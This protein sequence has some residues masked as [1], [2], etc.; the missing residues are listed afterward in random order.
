MRYEDLTPEERSRKLQAYLDRIYEGDVEQ[1]KES[2]QQSL[3]Q[4]EGVE[5][6]D[7]AGPN[8]AVETLDMVLGNQ[9]SDVQSLT[10]LET[11]E[12]V[13]HAERGKRPALDI[14]NGSYS[15]PVGDW[16]LLGD[17]STKT[18]IEN[19][20]PSIGRVELPE[21]WR[22]PYG[23]T[24]FVVGHNLLMTNRHVAHLFANGSGTRVF[25]FQRS[26]IDFRREL[27]RRGQPA[28][29]AFEITKVKMIHPYWDMAI[30]DVNP[31]SSDGYALPGPIVLS[32][33]DPS[34][35]FGDNVVVIGYPGDDSRGNVR[36]HDRIFRKYGHKRLQP[37]KLRDFADYESNAQRIVK[38]PVKNA[39]DHD[40]STLGGNSGSAVLL[41]DGVDGST[42]ARVVG[43]HFAGD[44]LER[45]YAVPVHELAKDSRV[46]DAGVQFTDAPPTSGDF[47]P[48]LWEKADRHAEELFPHAGPMNALQPA[49]QI[50][51]E[52]LSDHNN[53]FDRG[54]LEGVF[55]WQAT[56]STALASHLV[57]HLSGS[58]IESVAK[59][60]WGFNSCKFISRD[61]MECFVA[62]DDNINLVSFRG[63]ERSIGDWLTNL[64]LFTRTRSYGVVHRGFHSGFQSVRG[65]IEAELS[66]QNE[67]P[68]VLT[69]HSLGGALATIAA[70][71]WVKS[72]TYT[73]SRVYTFGQP[74]VGKEDF[75]DFITQNVGN[76][77]VR[78]VNDDDIVA[79]VPPT[80]D[81]VGHLLHLLPGSGDEAL[82][83][84][85]TL[86][87]DGML[88]ED[89][90]DRLRAH[91]LQQRIDR[92]SGVTLSAEEGF[93][94]SF[95]DHSLDRYIRRIMD[96]I[97]LP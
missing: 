80:F 21:D 17:T 39:L 62:A 97:G 2:L 48:Q 14:T 51:T 25:N 45:N 61:G 16:S 44:Y 33:E 26:E 35:F 32:A 20:I 13:I 19:A 75:S 29:T 12:A 24:A 53:H 95:R 5:T 58:E 69:G 92:N 84:V 60:E 93:F 76:K 4:T 66:N 56:L 37:G 83:P 8:E 88:T 87:S 31:T 11:I 22:R 94:P 63:T 27:P 54:S 73:V 85:E 91:C 34:G 86:S 30:L 10:A 81:H 38:H 7:F 67:L 57:Y 28:P 74:A 50:A 71:E 15:P 42:S 18:R 1:F 77:F 3:D 64:N 82:V 40:C 9:H 23:G 6:L 72:D 36:V 47:Y 41:I 96:E 55:S 65:L 70:A 90:F 43:L 79:R 78:V 59:D 89:Q 68:L 46:V 52:A 49:D